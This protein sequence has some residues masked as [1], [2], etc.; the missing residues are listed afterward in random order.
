MAVKNNQHSR[1]LGR[2]VTDSGAYILSKIPREWY[3]IFGDIAPFLKKKAT[4]PD[5]AARPRTEYSYLSHETSDFIAARAA[6]TAY[7]DPV[8]RIS[9][10]VRPS[11]ANSSPSLV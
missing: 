7:K 1:D 3:Y 4:S 10:C 8:Q 2:S 11:N 5:D 6:A 9:V